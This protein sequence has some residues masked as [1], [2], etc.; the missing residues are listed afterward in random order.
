MKKLIVFYDNNND[1]ELGVKT[2]RIMLIPNPYLS[3]IERIRIL[4]WIVNGCQNSKP[5]PP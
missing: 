2:E 1:H 5:N 3:S 4:I